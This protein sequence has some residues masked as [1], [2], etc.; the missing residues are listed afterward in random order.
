[1]N[2]YLMNMA[3]RGAGIGPPAVSK[4]AGGIRPDRTL[5]AFY[6]LQTAEPDPAPV[7]R[8]WAPIDTLGADCSTSIE[9]PAD[10]ERMGPP[11]LQDESAESSVPQE[12]RRAISMT[13]TNQHV[14]IREGTATRPVVRPATSPAGGQSDNRLSPD[15]GESKNGFSD[16]GGYRSEHPV[17]TNEPAISL[18]TTGVTSRADRAQ[19]ARTDAESPLNGL[20]RTSS[21]TPRPSG[22]VTRTVIRAKDSTPPSGETEKSQNVS[23]L[24]RETVQNDMT[25]VTKSH[26]MSPRT[27]S[28]REAPDATRGL[29]PRIRPSTEPSSHLLTTTASELRKKRPGETGR[30][31]ESD[32]TVHVRIGRVEVRAVYDAG[33]RPH[34]SPVSQPPCGGFDEYF[35]LRN[36]VYSEP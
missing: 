22:D 32:K 21:T 15:G 34:P 10:K 12:V 25:P 36:Y 11:E 29:M 30:A 16:D 6:G 24:T 27:A 13:M 26:V 3:G 4:T 2:H 1:M 8:S 35:S 17:P 20:A 19:G 23:G 9:Q 31:A 28:A 33:K 14:G 7:E 18:E 5:P